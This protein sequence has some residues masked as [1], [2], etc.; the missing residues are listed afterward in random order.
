MSERS[1]RNKATPRGQAPAISELHV[2]DALQIAHCAVKIGD[3]IIA[4]PE[5]FVGRGDMSRGGL[6]L[7]AARTGDELAYRSIAGATL[8]GARPPKLPRHSQ[9]FPGHSHS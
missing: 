2:Q 4:F 1:A 8:H 6:L 3:P 5:T 7:R 9:A